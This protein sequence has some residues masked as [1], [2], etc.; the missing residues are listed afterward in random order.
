[1]SKFPVTYDDDTSLPPINDNINEIGG[2]VV[3]SIRD[4]IFNLEHEIGIGASGS[5]STIANRLNVFLNPDGTPKPSLIS[6]LGLVTLP[7]YNNEIADAAGI[8]ERKLK[9]DFKTQD[10]FN[11][12]QNLTGDVNF[13]KGWIAVEGAKLD[14]HILGAAFRHTLSGIDVANFPA[15]F[16]TNKFGTVRNNDDAY[17]LIKDI[18]TD[19]VNHQKLDGGPV[20]AVPSIVTVRG[21]NYPSN[22]SHTGGAIYINSSRFGVIPQTINDLQNFANFIDSS[23]ALL[24][25]SRIV[26]LYSN[27]ISRISRSSTL[28][29]DGYGQNI[30]PSTTAT[31]YLLNTG[32]GSAPF[33]DIDHGDDVV[34]F[35][36]DA[37][38]IANNT[39]DAKFNLVKS[40]DILRINYGTVQVSFIIKEKKYIASGLT[41][42]YA[43]R[44]AGKNL[45][46]TTTASAR[47]DRP[48]INK[49]KYAELALAPA[50]NS[51]NEKASLIV[52]NPRSAQTVGLG[53]NANLLDAEHYLLY[54]ALYPTGFPQ[55][56]YVIL[57]GIDVTGDQGNS[58]GSY[59]IDNVVNATNKAFRKAG[60]NYRFAAF[61]SQGD[62]GLALADPYSN[63]SFS[64]LS[65]LIDPT[66]G[67]Y[68]SNGSK[69]VFAHNVID[70]FGV[71]ITTGVGKITDPLGLGPTR[72]NVA[73]PPYMTTY[74]SIGAAGTPTQI[75][76]PHRR[77]NYYVNG[78]EKD[79]FSLEVGQIL[80][81]Y[82]DGYW[83][84]TTHSHQSFPAPNGRVEKT[85][86]VPLDLSTSNLVN[87]KTIVV[88]P[89]ANVGSSNIIDDGRFTIKNVTFSN[90]GCA[91]AYTDIT[92]YDSVHGQGGSPAP[93]LGDGYAVGLYFSADSVTFNTESVSD[94]SSI[95]PFKRFFEI[96]IDENGKTFSNERCRM[97]LTGSNMIVNGT[98]LIGSLHIKNFDIVKVSPKLRGYLSGNV[99]KI[100]LVMDTYDSTTG[101]F[102]AY[103]SNYI[104]PN[105]LTNAGPP[106]SGRIGEV[107]RLY[108]DTYID[109]ID[110]ILDVKS[111]T[112]SFF[113]ESLDLQLFPTLSLDDEI[114]LLGTCQYVD[115][116]KQIGYIKDERQFGVI[117]EKDL[118]ISALNY[119]G[120]PEKLLH[121]NGV[122]KGLNIA[123]T[124]VVNGI[125]AANPLKNQLN[126]GGGIALVNGKIIEKNPETISI[127]FVKE[128]Y[129]SIQYSI[130]WAVCL[131]DK[132]E[133]QILPLLNY[134]GKNVLN[135][136]TV[137]RKFVSYNV[138]NGSQYVVDAI[139]FSD[140]INKR[141]DLVILYLVGSTITGSGSSAIISM[142]ISDV[143][144]YST[145]I[146]SNL[147]HKFTD[148]YSNQG[149]FKSSIAIFNWLKLN[150]T[151][152]SIGYLGGASESITDIPIFDFNFPTVID[153]QNHCSEEFINGFILG[154]NVTFKN[155][156]IY[157]TKP[158]TILTGAKNIIF[159][160][161]TILCSSF[162]N[163]PFA[164]GS[165]TPLSFMS[166]TN[167][168]FKNCIITINHTSGGAGAGILFDTCSNCSIINTTINSTFNSAD[169]T[170]T[171][172][173]VRLNNSNDILI[174]SLV[175]IG[176]F[177]QAIN[178][179]G[180]CNRWKVINS[181]FTTNRDPIVHS[182]GTY[183]ASVLV[184]SGRGLIN[185]Y[186]GTNVSDIT[187]DNT[188][189]N[190]NPAAPSNERYSFIMMTLPA[191]S[192]SY[193]NVIINNCKFNNLNVNTIAGTYFGDDY[194]A[195]VA[196]V[197]TSP[198][199][200]TNVIP[201]TIS[202]VKITNNVCNRSQLILLTSLKNAQTGTGVMKFPGLVANDVIVSNNICGTIG[203][204]IASAN[205]FVNVLNSTSFSSKDNGL[206][207]ADN[208][209]SFIGSMDALGVFFETN[210]TVNITPTIDLCEYPSGNVI[211]AN[212]KTN[213]IATGITRDSI[214]SLKILNNSLMAYNP[215]YLTP[216]SGFGQQAAV[217]IIG[218]GI[219]VNGN[220]H[221]N[222]GPTTTPGNNNN[223]NCLI[224]GNTLTEGYFYNASFV[225]TTY[226]YSVFMQI[227]T[228]AIIVDNICKNLNGGIFGA[229][230]L[231]GVNYIIQ[232]NHI[233]LG[234]IG[235]SNPPTYYIWHLPAL[236]VS[237]SWDG[238]GSTGIVSENYFDQSS[239]PGFGEQL[240][241]FPNN[242]LYE[243][244]I[245]QTAYLYLPLTNEQLAD[246][247]LSGLPQFPTGNALLAPG[248]MLD[249]SLIGTPG[250]L[251]RS[252]VLR[253]IDLDINQKSW[254]YQVNVDKY[255]PHNT[256]LVQAKIGFRSTH[257]FLDGTGTNLY[258]LS[259]ARFNLAS[260][261]DY[262]N[263][264]SIYG[265]TPV[266]PYFDITNS[267]MA[268]F[269][270]QTSSGSSITTFQLTV[271]VPANKQSLYTSNSTSPITIAL[272][273]R[274]KNMGGGATYVTY[275]SP[276]FIKYR[277]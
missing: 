50:N 136:P 248:F 228:S 197:N 15:N 76:V 218:V 153:G 167:V 199:T 159:D 128:I 205:R 2:T 210:T 45:L 99:N 198:T 12:I 88:Q 41:K 72:A 270:P 7:I 65:A 192:T 38:S 223:P 164:N 79:K 184:N 137:N 33:D 66:S 143:K 105:T 60:F 83:F 195:A 92:V 40:G 84:G 260:E 277:W 91:D 158:I 43:V 140:I 116:I 244:N 175:C 267:I 121:A 146:D 119:I 208:V 30:I 108:D 255:M 85:Y 58:T 247:N 110:I 154:S 56:G 156:T 254:A 57:P 78:N 26:N 194:R 191:V 236:I 144:R 132:S 263:L 230:Q 102:Q 269:N 37:G 275:F 139:S 19:F 123:S 86:R 168:N 46:Y 185:V 232:R 51:F 55:D 179:Q 206:T 170:I 109:Y 213:S 39:F 177:T 127:P 155:M 196:I 172:D 240:C 226:Y 225:S 242:W 265:D 75:F 173:C 35:M 114:M 243:K 47:I 245:N 126:I 268:N 18:N 186:A 246:Q 29:L 21:G 229:I 104:P 227:N 215:G 1:M 214:S 25:G 250:L 34:E 94:G 171:G 217:N 124:D 211:I 202:N 111:N 161:C 90:C 97:N 261:D 181:N 93:T 49:N 103:L 141:K 224:Q 23:S 36:P 174:D 160:N 27:G 44:I 71:G 251:S 107:T 219:Y 115:D 106:V 53:F 52:I 193:N 129:N 235:Q 176:N 20:G 151:Y 96:Y 61:N 22:Y 149:N 130:L 6:S 28:P 32:G 87:G 147:S 169:G 257:L 77:N 4:A 252:N 69:I 48:L 113:S 266:D 11:Y 8:L 122:V 16:I 10:L 241:S 188:T 200:S 89:I 135:N 63:A 233:N 256:K 165:T 59:T 262:T 258:T 166:A 73:S 249:G 163:I 117:S 204:W 152:N 120:A 74:G 118:S 273:L 14:P 80:D 13:S 131:N 145:D 253:I 162:I 201:P 231:G 216:Y 68:D 234:S 100:S 133:Y 264:A 112:A 81:T 82:G 134:D 101:I 222:G 209:C 98:T 276:L 180:N 31:A 3:N 125:A 271:N 207:I 70:V 148:V 24:L 54:L 17:Q 259:L 203:Y 42:K 187:I 95:G 157:M 274:W 221:K 142:K 64:I 178:V 138:I 237:P 239:L 150:N 220:S 9:L 272:D 189:F 238:T 190:Y 5:V 182:D 62:F 67:G 183:N 212:N